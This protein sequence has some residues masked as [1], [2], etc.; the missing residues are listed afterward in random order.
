MIETILTAVASVAGTF[1]GLEL[2]KYIANR[3]ARHRKEE[4]EADIAETNAEKE[5]RKMYEEWLS[6]TRKEYT[7]RINQLHASIT[8]SNDRYREIVKDGARKDEIIDDKTEHIRKLQTEIYDLQESR[9]HDALKL[10][11]LER[12]RDFYKNWH[13]VREYKDTPDGCLRRQPPQN[14]P[15][16]YVPFSQCIA[17]I[18][19]PKD[20]KKIADN[21]DTSKA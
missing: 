17:A 15:L 18:K 3:K 2:I 20:N 5:L 12:E 4:A 7:E 13:C 8:E 14:P 1:G 10:A 19:P 6:E 11:T 21:N 9:R 16:V